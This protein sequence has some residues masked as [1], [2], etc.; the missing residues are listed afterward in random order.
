MKKNN[1]LVP[2][3]IVAGITLILLSVWI[4]QHRFPLGFSH[5]KIARLTEK[6]GTVLFRNNEM[7]AEIEAGLKHEFESRDTLRTGDGAEAVIQFHSGGQF[8][9]LGN[10]ELLLERLENGNTLAMVKTGDITVEKFGS[11]SFWVRS[12]GRLYNAADYALLDKRAPVLG[13]RPR[14]AGANEQISQLE[15][16]NVLTGKKNDFFKCFG[17]LIQRDPQASGQVMLAFTIENQGTTTKLEISKSDIRDAAFKSCL[18]EVVARTRFRA[19]DGSPVATV[20][21]LKFE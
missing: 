12:E 11:P 16:E 2:G 18:L 7:P 19:F 13:G 8:R 9:M 1:W 4:P 14:E 6:T 15:I 10:T 5:D 20:F 21:P 17:Q 3:L